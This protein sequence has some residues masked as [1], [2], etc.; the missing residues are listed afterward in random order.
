MLIDIGVQLLIINAANFYNDQKHEKEQKYKE[1][2]ESLMN[3]TIISKENILICDNIN[4]RY[5]CTSLKRKVELPNISEENVTKTSNVEQSELAASYLLYNR[6]LL[7]ISNFILLPLYSIVLTKCG[8]RLPIIM[9]CLFVIFG[10]IGYI[11]CS[12]NI[13]KK[14]LDYVLFSTIFRPFSAMHGVFFVAASTAI[15]HGYSGKDLSER[16]HWLF[17]ARFV[18]SVLGYLGQG[19]L[20]MFVGATYVIVMGISLFILTILIALIFLSNTNV[21]ERKTCIE[22]ENYESIA[23]RGEKGRDTKDDNKHII[24]DNE[25]TS[26]MTINRETKSNSNQHLTSRVT[27]SEKCVQLNEKSQLVTKYSCIKPLK[28]TISNFFSALSDIFET[29]ATNMSRKVYRVC[30]VT[31]LLVQLFDRMIKMARKDTVYLYLTM[32]SWYEAEVSY[33]LAIEA[34]CSF[35]ILTF[36]VPFIT[37]VLQFGDYT[38]C[39]FVLF[40]RTVSFIWYSLRTSILE[41]YITTLLFMSPICLLLSAIRSAL[42]KLVPHENL[43]KIFTILQLMDAIANIAG[44]TLGLEFYKATLDSSP[45]VLFQVTAALSFL[46]ACAMGAVGCAQTRMVV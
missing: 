31:I 30:I 23:D 41:V 17:S 3:K 2:S 9:E 18:G 37:R 44:T 8:P 5:P 24:R 10:G 35:L 6:I 13:N 19:A 27:V 26:D 25:K 12:V 7:E 14:V 36:G 20:E 22:D 42:T 46:M 1:T 38:T 21:K 45:G 34:I 33:M 29:P 15:S 28:Q 43:I 16:H 39:A 11:F 4:L 32:S 40:S